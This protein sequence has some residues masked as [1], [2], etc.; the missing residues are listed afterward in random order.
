MKVIWTQ[1]F[2]DF[3]ASLNRNEV[4]YVLV[5]GYAVGWHGAPRVTKDVDFFI[6][7]SVENVERT[8][9]A[10]EDFGLSCLDF[11]AADLLAEN[12]GI[13]FGTPPY[14]VDVINFAQGI[15]F[16]EAWA[17]RIVDD[18]EGMALNVI[19]RELL[20]QNKRSTG[21]PQDQVD[22]AVLERRTPGR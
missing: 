1:D 11:S 10:I 14:R 5:G 9:R 2:R 20:I 8:I 22:A 17:S 18:L 21:R 12:S 15:T 7:R 6:E 3:V 4:K 16:E 13:F 19:N